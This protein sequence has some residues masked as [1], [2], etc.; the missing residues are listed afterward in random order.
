MER[1]NNYLSFDM[2]GFY[3]FALPISK[4][5]GRLVENVASKPK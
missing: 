1:D 4:N 3:L 2:F 5:S